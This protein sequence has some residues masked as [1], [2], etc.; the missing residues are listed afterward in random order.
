MCTK[1]LEKLN[2]GV[3]REVATAQCG[4]EGRIYIELELDWKLRGNCII[5]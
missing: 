4:E 3:L 2:L 5:V 1:I